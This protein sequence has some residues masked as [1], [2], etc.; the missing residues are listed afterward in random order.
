VGVLPRSC[1]SHKGA[2]FILHG[3]RYNPISTHA[4]LLPVLVLMTLPPAIATRVSRR[5]NI[6]FNP[7][8]AGEL[9]KHG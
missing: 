6:D 3:K 7:P 8:L 9:S 2:W 5:R 4:G 1:N